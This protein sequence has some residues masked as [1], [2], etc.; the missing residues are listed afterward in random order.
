MLPQK[1]A[2]IIDSIFSIYYVSMVSLKYI[3]CNE[4]IYNALLQTLIVIIIMIKIHGKGNACKADHY[5]VKSRLAIDSWCILNITKISV[6]LRLKTVSWSAVHN[7]I[8]NPQ[9]VFE[10]VHTWFLKTSF[11]CDICMCLCVCVCAC[12]R[13]CVHVC[14]SPRLYN[15]YTH[16]PRSLR[17]L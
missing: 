16:A 9:K 1:V 15:S 2:N 7:L 11:V 6:N 10:Q 17:I 12:A 13:V 5:M 3:W 8:N 14:L 4:F